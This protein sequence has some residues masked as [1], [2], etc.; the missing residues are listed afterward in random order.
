MSN[1]NITE[2][3]A[4]RKYEKVTVNG[5][6]IG[7]VRGEA[8]C[9]TIHNNH[10]L[11]KPPALASDIEALREAERLGAVYCVFTNADTGVTYTAAI[12]KVWQMGFVFNYGYGEQIAL[13]LNLWTQTQEGQEG[14]AEVSQ[15][16]VPVYS[17]PRQLSLFGGEND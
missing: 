5:R 9:K 10:I 1:Q 6:V 4:P 7:A 2:K 11:R 3:H 8:F 15:T 14:A 16:P 17:Q 13:P 12:A